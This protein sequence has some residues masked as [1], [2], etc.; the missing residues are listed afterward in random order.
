[1][2]KSDRND[3]EGGDLGKAHGGCG[4]LLT[5]SSSSKLPLPMDP[6]SSKFQQALSWAMKDSAKVLEGPLHLFI[7]EKT[8][9]EKRQ[10]H[11][12]A[13]THLL[14]SHLVRYPPSS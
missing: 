14:H 6:S 13:K 5:S 4:V 12:S 9:G 8:L 3:K 7:G 1:M 2:E 11:E 10:T